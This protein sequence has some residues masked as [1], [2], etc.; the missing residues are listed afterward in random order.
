MSAAPTSQS[1]PEPGGFQRDER[2]GPTLLAGWRRKTPRLLF[3]LFVLAAFGAISGAQAANLKA[4]IVQQFKAY[5]DEVEGRLVPRFRGEQFLWS[6]RSTEAHKEVADGQIAVEPAKNRGLIEIKGGMIQ[7]W[8]GAVFIKGANLES[9]LRVVQDYDNHA[10]YYSPDVVTAKVV[11]HTDDH[12]VVLM[13]TLKSK[14]FLT[15]VLETEDDI[16]FERVNSTMAYGISKSRRIQEVADPGKG[17]EHLLPEGHDR[18]LLWRLYG[19]W[20]YE[21]RD[22]G[23][24]VE[25][26]SVTLTRDVPFGM[27]AVVAPIIR[28]VPGESLRSGLEHTRQA[29][30]REAQ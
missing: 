24:Y 13:R 15:D 20:F 27:G 18:G 12:W 9:V 28:N 4:E 30:L 5:I 16:T 19:Y 7:D 29:V 26:E 8:Q 2:S 3:R 1:T 21:E 11:S 17:N 25:C 22:R 23:V 10:K 14:L 6:D